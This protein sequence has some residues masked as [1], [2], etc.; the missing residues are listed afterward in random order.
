MN[1]APPALWPGP[2]PTRS[3][4]RSRPPRAEPPP[5]PATCC[6][7]C[8]LLRSQPDQLSHGRGNASSRPFGDGRW[9]EVARLYGFVRC[10]SASVPPLSTGHAV[11]PSLSVSDVRRPP[12]RTGHCWQKD[13]DRRDAQIAGYMG[14]ASVHVRNPDEPSTVSRL[15]RSPCCSSRQRTSRCHGNQPSQHMRHGQAK[16]CL[17]P[18][19]IGARGQEGRAPVHLARLFTRFPSWPAHFSLC[20]SCMTCWSQLSSRPQRLSPIFFP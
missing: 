2:R 6:W 10:V 5:L 4:A 14:A 13:G 9:G 7:P 19:R 3:A 17:V 12:D 16:R 1:L 8:R 20:L 15:R 18:V 11:L